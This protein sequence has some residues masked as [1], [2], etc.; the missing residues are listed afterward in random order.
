MCA[1]QLLIVTVRIFLDIPHTHTHT[2]DPTAGGSVDWAMGIEGLQLAYAFEFR[3]RPNGGY[4]FML[5]GD[6]IVPNALE[7]FDGIRAMIAEARVLK[8]L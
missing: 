3:D 8:Y 5:P 1:C 2:P 4:G 7:A 6:Q